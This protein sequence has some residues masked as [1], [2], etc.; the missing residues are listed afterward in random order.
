[1]NIAVEL[2]RSIPVLRMEGRLD[3]RGASMLDEKV[4]ALPASTAHLV[5]DM[6]KVDY[7]SS[8]GIRSLIVTEKTLRGRHGGVLLVGVTPFVAKV[9]EMVG[10]SREF[11]HFDRSGKAVD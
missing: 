5:M 3:A 1:M 9:L 2:D 4:A 7:L 6:T 11:Q 8:I 10:L